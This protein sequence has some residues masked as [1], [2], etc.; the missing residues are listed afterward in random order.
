MLRLCS[1][2]PTIHKSLGRTA[3]L[4]MDHV[5]SLA[6]KEVYAILPAPHNITDDC[7]TTCHERLT[8]AVAVAI[9]E[10]ANNRCF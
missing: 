2:H 6:P 3:E 1:E 4:H 8:V 7:L 10:I 9:A 5:T